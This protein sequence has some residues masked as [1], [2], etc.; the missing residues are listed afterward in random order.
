MLCLWYYIVWFRFEYEIVI[1]YI[2]TFEKA[3]ICL[4]L[5][6]FLNII[7][8][9]IVLQKSSFHMILLVKIFRK[10]KEEMSHWRKMLSRIA[11]FKSFK[12]WVQGLEMIWKIDFSMLWMVTYQMFLQSFQ[13]ILAV[14]MRGIYNWKAHKNKHKWQY[15]HWLSI[16][17]LFIQLSCIVQSCNWVEL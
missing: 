8:W 3:K 10:K 6:L 5:L 9:K 14:K 2:N 17:L 12:D 4:N 1:H 7:L 16:D 13:H 11:N 15:L